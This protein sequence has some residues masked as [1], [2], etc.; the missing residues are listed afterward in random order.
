M[1][2][3]VNRIYDYA[4]SKRF[5]IQA[6]VLVHRLYKQSVVEYGNSFTGREKN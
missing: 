4:H 3:S 1:R 2:N 5:L 6:A